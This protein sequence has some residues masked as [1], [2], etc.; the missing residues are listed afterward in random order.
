MARRDQGKGAAT[1][2]A[3]STAARRS[4]SEELARKRWAAAPEFFWAAIV[5]FAAIFLYTWTLSPTVTLVDS[6][7][8]ILA[9]R[10]L[11]VAH[12]PGFP[13][14]VML[15]HLFSLAP[16]G[17]IAS[18]INFSSAVFGAF[19]CATL[20]LVVAELSVA[21]SYL[22]NSKQ[23]GGRNI[24]VRSASPG[25][26]VTE[27]LSDRL[28][29]LVPA[30]TAGLLLAF[31]RTL[32]TYAT[33]TEVYALNTLLLLLIFFLM[34]RWRHRIMATKTSNN[35]L[36]YAA[37]LLFGL[38]L[39]VHHVTIALTLPAL[40]LIVYR[41]QGWAFFKSRRLVFA[42]LFSTVALVA[43]YLYLPVA[44]SRAPVLNWGDPVSANA[45]WSHI[46][47]RQYQAFLS[48]SPTR[49]AEQFVPL[50]KMVLRE[51]GFPWLPLG[52]ALA[53]GGLA[54]AFR[55]DRTIFWFLALVAGINLAY[56]LIYDIAEDKDA[57]CL[58]AF[59]AFA[60][61]AG[62]GVRGL[63]QF[64]LSRSLHPPKAFRIATA[65]VLATISVTFLANW[66]FNNRRYYFIAHDYVDN[67][68]GS[69]K[70]NGLL[71]TL[72]WQ[73]ASPFLYVQEIE[74]RRRDVKVLDVNLMRRSWYF[75]YLRQ[76]H[77]DLIERSRDRIDAYVAE[78]KQWEENP[79]AYTN[80][81][82][83][84]S[85]IASKFVEMIQ[86][87]VERENQIAP[88]YITR[89]LI[90]SADHDVALTAWFT[91][92]YALVPEGLVFHLERDGTRFH[93]PGEIQWETR[94]L[95]DGTLKFETDDV[96][97]AKVLP[98]YTAMLINRG[99]YFTL[100]DE[101]ERAM[102]AYQ[103]AL[104]LDPSLEMARRGLNESLAK[105]PKR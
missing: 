13:L 84:T 93:D 89:E 37:A 22:G 39:G 81:P 87:C 15:A 90:T 86:T 43:V 17:S 26:T 27:G 6:G 41:T 75:D 23:R 96:V 10:S 24:A 30:V 53:I 65:S 40:G 61:A 3:K 99:R 91:R 34:L 9:A 85:M 92:N 103:Q 78:L 94:G 60:I 76:I 70:P 64:L 69:I 32:W 25:T 104:A 19:A 18:C 102:A 49:V 36:L 95:N 58:P 29:V 12:P 57:Y 4:P 50:A 48:F 73:V 101:Q 98:A 45:I 67:I 66:P 74:N 7:E 72:D 2:R 5:F 38:A 56:T 20:T 33:V 46:T 68:L 105:S 83:L 71:F 11:G 51:F 42:A 63:M 88:V 59:V 100:F 77:P 55:R 44:A 82:T 31:S 54:S 79:D 80:N 62:L 97:S 14:W 21:A 8:L 47:G 52:M 16:F 28:L 35:S 1:D